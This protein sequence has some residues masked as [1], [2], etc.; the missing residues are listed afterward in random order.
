MNLLR[1]PKIRTH[2]VPCFSSSL[3]FASV[4]LLKLTEVDEHWENLGVALP[5]STS[6]YWYC[7]LIPSRL[8]ILSHFRVFPK[9]KLRKWFW[10]L[11]ASLKYNLSTVKF[12][13][14]FHFIE[15]LSCHYICSIFL[16]SENSS[17][18]LFISWTQSVTTP[19]KCTIS[20]LYLQHWPISSPLHFLIKCCAI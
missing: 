1:V 20:S 18:C 4:L 2:L 15:L 16:C 13:G 7:S 17:V 12:I 10:F 14:P 3:P 19:N 6:T 11:T 9:S 8:T 5:D